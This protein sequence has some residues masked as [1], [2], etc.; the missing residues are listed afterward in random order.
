MCSSRSVGLGL[1]VQDQAASVEVGLQHFHLLVFGIAGIQHLLNPQHYGQVGIDRFNKP[2]AGDVFHVCRGSLPLNPYRQGK[3]S[4]P[5]FGNLRVLGLEQ[6]NQDFG[7][8]PG[9][10]RWSRR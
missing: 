8:I 9:A 4:P 3:Q 5:N 2:L 6:F 7:G 10:G 1:A